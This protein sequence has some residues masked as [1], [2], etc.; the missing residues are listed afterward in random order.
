MAKKQKQ[1]TVQIGNL[2][3]LITFKVSADYKK[4]RMKVVTFQNMTQSVRGRWTSH[5]I[6]G[7]K[8]VSE[9][10][11]PDMRQITL[12]IVLSV[13]LGINPRKVLDSLEKAVEKGS[14]YD[15]VIGGKKVGKYQWCITGMSE[16][17]DIVMNNGMLVQAKVSLT[18][19]EYR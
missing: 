1:K 3:K 5:A 13:D 11:G 8:P 18:L 17:W 16:T 2:G 15:F 14:A 9:F 10:L 7:K 4:G 6:I 19:E 12:P